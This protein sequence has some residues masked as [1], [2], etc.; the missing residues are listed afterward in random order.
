MKS[1]INIRDTNITLVQH[2]FITIFNF[3]VLDTKQ[4]EGQTRIP[5]VEEK[6]ENLN[7]P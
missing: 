4:L 5:S 6:N 2:M 3:L 7:E 1:Y